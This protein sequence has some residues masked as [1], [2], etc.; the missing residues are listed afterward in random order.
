V[1]PYVEFAKQIRGIR[2]MLLDT[3]VLIDGRIEGLADSGFI[4]SPV[5]VPGFVINELQQ[6]ADSGDKLKRARGRRGLTMVSTLQES[7]YLDFSLDNTEYAGI[8]SVDHLLL[9]VAKEQNLRILTTDYNLNKVAQIQGVTVLN[10]NDL[11]GSLKSHAVPGEMLAVEIVKPGE[12]PGQGV[13]YMPDGTMVVVEHAG[14]S[15][16]QLVQLSVTNSLQ[17]SAGRMIFGKMIEVNGQREEA[18]AMSETIARA[19]T[20]Q[21]RTTERPPRAPEHPEQSRRNPRR[22]GWIEKVTMVRGGSRW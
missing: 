5:I 15:I 8:H 2:P 1:I 17:T 12:G 19:A 11:A 9:K 10:I 7:P 3:S 21:P 22:C 13:G 6:L 16:G 4:D 20:N 18:E 14:E